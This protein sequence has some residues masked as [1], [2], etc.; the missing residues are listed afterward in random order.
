[1]APVLHTKFEAPLA[2]SVADPPMQIAADEALT[3][4]IGDGLTNTVTLDVAEQ[5]L[6]F[7]PVT[8]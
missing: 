6:A 4:T 8:E 5:P 7:V 3:V 2:V 1:M